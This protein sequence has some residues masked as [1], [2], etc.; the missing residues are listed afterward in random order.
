MKIAIVVFLSLSLLFF[1]CVSQRNVTLI[2]KIE[3][4]E[5][6]KSKG[7]NITLIDVRTVEEFE[8]G[9]INSAQNIDFWDPEF[10]NKCKKHLNKKNKIIV[11][12]AGGGRSA[13]AS[14][15]LSKLGFKAIYDLEGGYESFTQK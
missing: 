1:S 9:T 5:I 6:L 8:K 2:D 4:S 11:F 7:E 3:L 15:R 12:C 13:M 14:K 10:E